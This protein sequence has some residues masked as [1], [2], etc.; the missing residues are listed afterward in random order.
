MFCGLDRSIDPFR[1]AG[2]RVAASG[3]SWKEQLIEALIAGYNNGGCTTTIYLPGERGQRDGSISGP[4]GPVSIKYDD[5]LHGDDAYALQDETWILYTDEATKRAQLAC[6]APGYN[7]R[8]MGF[9]Y[10][11]FNARS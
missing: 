1:L 8:L 4:L 6:M 3:L 9:D 5:T 2:V 11:G 7:V 10:A